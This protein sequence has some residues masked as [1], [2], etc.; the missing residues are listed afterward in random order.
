MRSVTA[1]RPHERLWYSCYRGERVMKA[2]RY[3]D[4]DRLVR[5]AARFYVAPRA[6]IAFLTLAVVGLAAFLVLL[7]VAF[8]VLHRLGA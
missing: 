8:S 6:A 5:T 3:D 4:S 7:S 1:P 2:L